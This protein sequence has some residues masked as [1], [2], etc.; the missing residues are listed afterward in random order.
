MMDYFWYNVGYV[1]IRYT[2]GSVE[3]SLI[4]SLV[5][6]YWILTNP[7]HAAALKLQ[8]ILLDIL[9]SKWQ[10]RTLRW[11]TWL[12]HIACYWLL[13]VSNAVPL[14]CMEFVTPFVVGL[15]LTRSKHVR[16]ILVGIVLAL[17]VPLRLA[18]P[19]SVLIDAN[20]YEF[21]AI[22]ILLALNVFWFFVICW[23][24]IRAF[25]YESSL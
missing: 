21:H 23:T 15:H 14:L 25:G 9:C 12:S 13:V 1:Y 2:L 10:G 6:C 4:S 20:S 3:A 11:D 5:I 18:L 19:L 17:W 7:V 24:T 22:A 16:A 8:Y